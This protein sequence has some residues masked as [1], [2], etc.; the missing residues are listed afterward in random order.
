MSA[1]E[2]KSNTWV[3]VIPIVLW[4]V[5][6]FFYL[7]YFQDDTNGK[8]DALFAA[9]ISLFFFTTAIAQYRSGYFWKNGAP[10][11]HG[12]HRSVCPKRFKI[13]TIA[14]L[15]IGMTIAGFFFYQYCNQ[16]E[17]AGTEQP[18]TRTESKSEGSDKPKPESEPASR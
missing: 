4:F 14:H 10:P 11:N 5:A 6:A 18:A 7:E 13:S 8:Y 12:K 1:A 15:M 3:V 2:S 16:G 9:G 17:Q